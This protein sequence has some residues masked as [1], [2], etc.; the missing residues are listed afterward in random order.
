MAMT[1]KEMM[2][3]RKL[4]EKRIIKMVELAWRKGAGVV[5][6]GAW[7]PAMT[8]YGELI[9]SSIPKTRCPAITTG[10]AF[11]AWAIREYVEKLVRIRHSGSGGV[12]VGI[13]GAAGSTGS[14]TA[15]LLAD[16][17][18]VDGVSIK[19]LL[20][21]R[22]APDKLGA[23]ESLQ[24]ELSPKVDVA[25]SGSLTSLPICDYIVT[26][27][28]SPRSILRKQHVT[29][30]TVVI[31]DSQPRNTSPELRE[32]GIHVVDVLAQIPN[33]DAHFDFGIEGADTRVSFT[34]MAEVVLLA[35]S[36]KV[37][38]FSIG[39]VSSDTIQKLENLINQAKK[40]SA[41]FKTAPWHAFGK[42]MN[43]DEVSSLE[44]PVFNQIAAE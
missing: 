30:G 18:S 27:T 2:R 28:N 3:H 25:V 39:F 11:T 10:H 37:V 26:V 35:T 41:V 43:K 15:R 44:A 4:A 17:Q 33:F 31:D 9:Q 12:I 16:L 32:A 24:N 21:E 20:V 23:I 38:D 42:P 1:P 19:L 40:A 29:P 14:L 13:V 36:N 6:L 5:G 8:G 7:L 34:C 22:A